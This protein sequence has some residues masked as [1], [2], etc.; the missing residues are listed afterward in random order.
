[1]GRSIKIDPISRIEGHL[2]IKV[3]V[4]SDKVV[5]AFS[6]GEMFR[7]FETIL[8]GRD[9]LDAQ[10][11]TQRICGVCPISHGT[12]SVLAQDMAYK[13]VPPENG[14]LARNIILAANYI[15]SHII[16]F[17][18]LSALDFVDIAAITRYEGKDQVLKDLK[19]WV[20][21]QMAS[22]T[23]YPAAPFLPRY[24]SKYIE[25]TELNITAIKHYLDALEIRAL[26]QKMGAV[27]GGKLPHSTTLVPGGVTEKVT[28]NKIAICRE[29]LNKL[30]VFINN[31]YIP[32]VLEVAKSFPEYFDIGKGYGNFLAYGVFQESEGTSSAFFPSGVINDGSLTTFNAAEISE[33]VKYSFYSSQ[34][35]LKPNEGSTIPEPGKSGAY[36]WL[37]SPRY[38]GA[39]ME[40]GPLAR[41]MVAYMGTKNPEVNQL[42][43]NT[44]AQLDLKPEALIS[45]F[46]RHAAR[47]LEAKVIADRCALWIEQLTPDKPSFKDF[48]I[49][50]TGEGTGLTEAP[51]GALGH[52]L[53][54]KDHKIENYQ[55]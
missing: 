46:G 4:E 45:T 1:M 52:W 43:N 40:V 8:R 32:D 25:D 34:S 31:A 44:L 55:C 20:Q 3:D 33:D 16:H 51:R 15:Q 53:T 48:D 54:I 7:G 23:L 29:I 11:I 19:A 9:P 18:Q 5:K 42:V 36:S 6:S 12:A 26:A 50:E 27:F 28:A 13:I 35:G 49:P 39:V 47:A 38:K 30:R 37:K 22:N 14:R 2:A 21:S 17:Y 24:D 10:Q 41:I